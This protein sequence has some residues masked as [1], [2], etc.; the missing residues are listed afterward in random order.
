MA[1]VLTPILQPTTSMTML[2][3]TADAFQTSAPGQPH[4]LQSRTTQLPRGSMYN[5]KGGGTASYRGSVGPIAPYAFQST[6]NLRQGNR[7]FPAMADTYGRQ[8]MQA[9]MVTPVGAGHDSSS[10]STASSSS[11]FNPSLARQFGTKD[12]TAISD[13][14]RRFGVETNYRP[15]STISLSSGLDLSPPLEL[16]ARPSPD[17]FRRNRRPATDPQRSKQHYQQQQQQQ[18]QSVGLNMP[19]ISGL[20]PFNNSQPSTVVL[21]VPPAPLRFRSI[22]ADDSQFQRQTTPMQANMNR[23][24]SLGSIETSAF[25]PV[26]LLSTS[27]SKENLAT[28]LSSPRS[29]NAEATATA[30]ASFTFSGSNRERSGSGDSASST[31][32]Q[33]RPSSVSV[34]LRFCGSHDYPEKFNGPNFKRATK[35]SLWLTWLIE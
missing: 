9:A 3:S 19:T 21:P 22:S 24:R 14:T 31:R 8:N 5:A 23:R 13:A 10:A 27:S 34:F 32:S 29:E 7:P 15:M 18:R 28:P 17:R 11:S 12:D 26:S 16:Q 35:K 33:S 2:H 4:H 20:V 6:P 25:P 1:Q 30:T